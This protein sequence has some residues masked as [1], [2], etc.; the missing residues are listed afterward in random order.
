VKKLLPT[1]TVEIVPSK[2]RNSESFIYCF[3][4]ILR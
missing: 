3:S 4:R 2:S 1:S